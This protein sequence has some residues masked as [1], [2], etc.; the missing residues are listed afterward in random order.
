M[1]I[2]V[3]GYDSGCQE[4]AGIVANVFCGL[5]RATL[6]GQQ[7]SRRWQMR[8]VTTPDGYSAAIADL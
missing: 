8:G 7:Y 6:R 3:I 4:W 5:S 1:P 2:R